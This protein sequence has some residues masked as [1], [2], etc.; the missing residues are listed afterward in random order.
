MTIIYANILIGV[1]NMGCLI[2]REYSLLNLSVSLCNFGLAWAV[3]LC[4]PKLMD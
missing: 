3:Y 2:F 4:S 1:L